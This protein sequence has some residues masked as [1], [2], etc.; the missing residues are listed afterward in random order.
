MKDRDING[1]RL[2]PGDEVYYARKAD[3]SATGE[4]VKKVVT[5]ISDK[6]VHMGKYLSTDPTHQLLKR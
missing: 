4:L 1:T 6:G 3:Y 5:K 2:I